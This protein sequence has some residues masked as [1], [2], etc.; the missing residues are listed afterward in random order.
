MKVPVNTS[1]T[2]NNWVLEASVGRAWK[3]HLVTLIM[4]FLSWDPEAGG[5]EGPLSDMF[6]WNSMVARQ[7]ID[8]ACLS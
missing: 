7:D 6:E 1:V 2:L 3:C 4:V 8:S 5:A